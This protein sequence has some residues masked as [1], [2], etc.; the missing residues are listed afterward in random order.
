MSMGLSIMGL[1]SGNT[2][3]DN[4]GGSSS[5]KDGKVRG[6]ELSPDEHWTKACMAV[7]KVLKQILIAESEAEKEVVA[8]QAPEVF[9]KG[10]V[11]NVAG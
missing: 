2:N 5:G 10:M 1:G 8:S 7:L 9:H 6:G 4:G 3:D 11:G